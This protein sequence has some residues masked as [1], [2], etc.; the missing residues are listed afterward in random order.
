MPLIVRSAGLISPSKRIF[1]SKLSQIFIISK[2]AFKCGV[3]TEIIKAGGK[4]PH[5]LFHLIPS[6]AIAY[7]SSRM[8]RRLENHV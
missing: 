8:V 2:L 5:H 6:W 3:G 4:I 1:P 7:Y